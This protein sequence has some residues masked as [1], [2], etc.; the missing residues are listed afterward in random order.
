MNHTIV[1]LFLSWLPNWLCDALECEPEALRAAEGNF[2]AKSLGL[3]T[4]FPSKDFRSG[5][6]KRERCTA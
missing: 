3:K 4:R 1:I 2:L 5:W 6:W